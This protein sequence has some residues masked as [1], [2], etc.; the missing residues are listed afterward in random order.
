MLGEPA[1]P[2]AGGCYEAAKTNQT[3]ADL[4]SVP[5]DVNRSFYASFTVPDFDKFMKRAVATLEVPALQR[6]RRSGA[7]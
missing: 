2:G 6:R 1:M 3:V 4:S 7:T 5:P